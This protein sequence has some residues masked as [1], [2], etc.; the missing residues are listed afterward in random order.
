MSD[1]RQRNGRQFGLS[2]SLSM[3]CDSDYRVDNRLDRVSPMGSVRFDRFGVPC[4]DSSALSSAL[5]NSTFPKKP[6]RL[7]MNSRSIGTAMSMAISSRPTYALLLSVALC[8]LSSFAVSAEPLDRGDVNAFDRPSDVLV[9]E[10][11]RYRI[12]LYAVRCLSCP[13]C[14]FYSRLPRMIISVSA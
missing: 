1:S 8:L 7:I 10:D 12:G 13:G 6:R 14:F 5:T 11:I 9:L 3:D 4:G 2:G